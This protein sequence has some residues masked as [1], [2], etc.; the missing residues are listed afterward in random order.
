MTSAS[1]SVLSSVLA[2][3]AKTP[4]VNT[5][6]E[7]SGAPSFSSTLQKAEKATN[8]QAASASNPAEKSPEANDSQVKQ[9]CAPKAP[10]STPEEPA[11]AETATPGAKPTT[12][13]PPDQPLLDESQIQAEVARPNVER[14]ANEET[15]LEGAHKD[16]DSKVDDPLA[17]AP[18]QQVAPSAV[19]P[20][21]LPLPQPDQNSAA[22]MA[23]VV[24]QTQPQSN[25]L[26]S[27]SSA[28]EETPLASSIMASINLGK[29]LDKST[30]TAATPSPEKTQATT[31]FASALPVVQGKGDDQRLTAPAEVP[32]EATVEPAVLPAK[33]KAE[34]EKA[35]TAQLPESSNRLEGVNSA[36]AATSTTP[37]Q[38]ASVSSSPSPVL[39]T[40]VGNQDW[41]KQLGQQL[42]NFHL[43]GEQ[44]VQLHLN[45]AN[46]GPMSITLNVNEHLQATAHFSSHSS[47]VRSA[48]EQGIG[49]LRESMAEQGISLGQTSV[50]EQRQQNFAQEKGSQSAS[51]S[52]NFAAGSELSVEPSAP[53]ASV[54]N[55]SDGEISTYA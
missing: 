21:A 3:A 31:S 39:Q 19:Q 46:L 25:P 8:P 43:K 13:T 10:E 36:I 47:Q 16:A 27:A 26:A 24:T 37:A 52:G 48:L 38:A 45:P 35:A 4:Q 17:V 53:V 18:L 41:A 2:P 22:L 33:I 54:R 32:V 50:G 55:L 29:S 20:A 49:Q 12:L 15:T 1:V 9:T 5:A 51:F 14:A 11:A 34:P 44:N 42:V 23:A 30:G 6:S 40:P 28:L 7:K